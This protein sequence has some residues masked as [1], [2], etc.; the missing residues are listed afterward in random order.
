MAISGLVVKPDPINNRGFNNRGFKIH[1]V[2]HRNDRPACD[3]Y[4]GFGSKARCDL[5]INYPIGGDAD[6]IAAAITI[7]FKD[8]FSVRFGA[9]CLS[10]RC[11]F[12]LF[13]LG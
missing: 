9:V 8:Q 6:C 12:A 10:S 2:L 5:L 13:Q 4:K 7:D 11:P 3:G 1:H